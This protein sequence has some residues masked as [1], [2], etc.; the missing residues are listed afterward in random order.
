M[1]EAS[2]SAITTSAGS[3]ST[4]SASLAGRQAAYETQVVLDSGGMDIQTTGGV[5]LAD[6]GTT[7]RIGQSG[8]A[9]T[10]IT[11]TEIAMYDGQGTPR[12]RVAIDN[13]GKAAFGGAAGADVSVSST[14]DVVRITPGSG[15]SIFED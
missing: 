2:S 10:E 6:Y 7:I 9:R 8:E 3:L 14:D 15:V 4:V 1:A 11:N 12:K 5:S 13:T